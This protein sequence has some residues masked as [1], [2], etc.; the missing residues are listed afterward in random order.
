MATPMKRWHAVTLG[1]LTIALP[2][3]L[4][5]WR[6]G[7]TAEDRLACTNLYETA[8]TSRDSAAVDG[9]VVHEHSTRTPRSALVSCGDLRRAGQL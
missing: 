8:R 2:I 3:G 4:A 5:W 6:R 9:M 7:P 1:I